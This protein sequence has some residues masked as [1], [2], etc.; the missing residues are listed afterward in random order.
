LTTIQTQIYKYCCYSFWI[1]T[2]IK[3]KIKKIYSE[4]NQKNNSNEKKM[5]ER[6]KNNQKLIEEV[7][8]NKN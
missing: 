1:P 7:Q 3:E 6:P 4:Q 2:K 5:P 8:K